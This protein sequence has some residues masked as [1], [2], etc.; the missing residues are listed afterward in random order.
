[1]L[2]RIR[3][4]GP[5][6]CVLYLTA[7]HILTRHIQRRLRRFSTPSDGSDPSS[8]E[9]GQKKPKRV[10]LSRNPRRV[11]TSSS[12]APPNLK[13]KQSNASEKQPSKKHKSANNDDPARKYCLGK[14]QEIFCRIFLKYP[15]FRD[16]TQA[17]EELDLD[18][19]FTKGADELA[20]EEKTQLE[21][22]AKEY[23]TQV[24]IAMFETHSEPD[25]SGRSA[26][27]GKYK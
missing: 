12:P 21:D 8:G 23:A 22:K 14:L 9:D 5:T 10:R 7:Q 11:H 27:A 26:A 6:R 13:R 16:A 15:Y 2:Q 18:A 19:H 25:R 24:E 20:D 4:R 3:S 1:M 17:D